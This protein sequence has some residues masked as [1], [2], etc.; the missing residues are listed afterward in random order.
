MLSEGHQRH[1]APFG[2]LRTSD[3]QDHTSYFLCHTQAFA[4][5]SCAEA[6]AEADIASVRTQS[7]AAAATLSNLNAWVFVST[8]AHKRELHRPRQFQ[9]SSLSPRIELSK[10]RSP[11]PL[12]HPYILPVLTDYAL[13]DPNHRRHARRLGLLRSRSA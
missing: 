7:S 3:G 8:M 13:H 9:T 4:L 1:S 12:R 11:I 5:T 6:N 2:R 10:F